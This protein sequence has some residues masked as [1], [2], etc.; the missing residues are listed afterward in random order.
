MPLH[1]SQQ[2]G[3]QLITALF[4]AALLIAKLFL[5]ELII[6]SQEMT[7]MT[8]IAAW[9]PSPSFCFLVQGNTMD[10]FVFV[11]WLFI[12]CWF[13][14]FFLCRAVFQMSC[15]RSC[16]TQ[17]GVGGAVWTVPWLLSGPLQ[18]GVCFPHFVCSIPVNTHSCF[19]RVSLL[20]ANSGY[21]P[22]CFPDHSQVLLGYSFPF[23][24]LYV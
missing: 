22:C 21:D 19:A 8:A 20:L 24:H 23:W 6:P 9:P 2:N 18:W 15:W 12:V 1:C 3:K 11:G 14:F 7:I 13:G 4:K 17:D 16:W 10:G 5:V